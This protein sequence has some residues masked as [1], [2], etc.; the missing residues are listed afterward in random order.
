M[1]HSVPRIPCPQAPDRPTI[2][3][4]WRR[5]HNRRFLPVTLHAIQGLASDTAQEKRKPPAGRGSSLHPIV[6]GRP[7][8]A[9]VSPDFEFQ[10]NSRDT[11]SNPHPS[12]APHT[13]AIS[14]PARMS[15]TVVPAILFIT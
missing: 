14:I 8:P 6:F 11:I 15:P 7:L 3:R 5:P 10:A 2:L 12:N 13:P 1:G 4:G 9:I